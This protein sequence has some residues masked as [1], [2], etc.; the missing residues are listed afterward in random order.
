MDVDRLLNWTRSNLEMRVHN[1]KLTYHTIYQLW[2]VQDGTKWLALSVGR[3]GNG[4][5]MPLGFTRFSPDEDAYGIDWFG[6][7]E[8]AL[9]C[10]QDAEHCA[11]IPCR[12]WMG[13]KKCGQSTDEIFRFLVYSWDTVNRLL[14]ES[15]LFS[16]YSR[17]WSFREYQMPQMCLLHA[18]FHIKREIETGIIPPKNKLRESV[19]S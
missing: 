6:V 10:T 7:D 9:S 4:G 1:G 19:P 3:L 2:H 13:T 8:A 5:V 12:F 14:F 17:R 16:R 18:V 11:R 15:V